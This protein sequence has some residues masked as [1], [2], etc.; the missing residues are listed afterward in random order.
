MDVLTNLIVVVTWQ[1]THIKIARLYTLNL[2]MSYFN[3]ISIKL[4]KI[5]YL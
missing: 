4:E 3:C 5:F 1:Y 2:L